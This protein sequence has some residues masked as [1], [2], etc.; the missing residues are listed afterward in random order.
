M[1]DISYGLINKSG[2]ERNEEKLSLGITG[3]YSNING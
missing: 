2:T 3:V 1:G